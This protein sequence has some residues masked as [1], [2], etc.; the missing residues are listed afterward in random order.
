MEHINPC[1]LCQSAPQLASFEYG[2]RRLYYVE[3]VNDGCPSR[4]VS[5]PSWDASEAVAEWNAA[6]PQSGGRAA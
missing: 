1:C 3:C 4:P 6:N 2:V 5:R